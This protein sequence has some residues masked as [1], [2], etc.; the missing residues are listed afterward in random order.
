MNHSFFTDL[1]K[2]ILVA[3]RFW[4][5]CI[6]V[7]ETSMCKFLC[8]LEFLTGGTYGKSLFYTKPLLRVAVLFCIPSN[9]EW[10]FHLSISSP[11]FVASV[12]N[13]G[14]SNWHV[15]SCLSLH[16]P[17]DTCGACFHRLVISV[18]SLERY[19]SLLPIVTWR[20]LFSCCAGLRVLPV[21]WI[22]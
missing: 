20:F 3:F 7:P 12:L 2:N 22:L 8:G 14:Y 6:K 21:F 10:E 11:P 13:F 18:S 9:G 19:P 17:N 5:L 4:H 1:P 15:N 16:F